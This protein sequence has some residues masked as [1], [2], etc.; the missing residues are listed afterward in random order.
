MTVFRAFLAVFFVTLLAYTLKVGFEYGWN[1][2][3][4]FFEELSAINW[5]GQFNFDFMGFLM[6]SAIWCA[7]RN[8]F[9]P[10][11]FGLA[12]LGATGG[13]LFL[14]A[15]LLYLSFATGGDIKTMMLGTRRASE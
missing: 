2:I 1:L 4:L 14:T 13:M 12:I 8:N 11:G 15:Y 10:L 6:L 7:W 9:T 3:P 5:Q